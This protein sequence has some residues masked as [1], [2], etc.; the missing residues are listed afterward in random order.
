MIVIK[1]L[2]YCNNLQLRT[3]LKVYSIYGF[4]ALT[5][6]DDKDPITNGEQEDLEHPYHLMCLKVT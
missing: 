3:Q 6:K 2:L 5:N 1:I 4:I